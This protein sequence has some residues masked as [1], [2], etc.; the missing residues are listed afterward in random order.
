MERAFSK[1]AG[2]QTDGQ[3]HKRTPHRHVAL[4]VSGQWTR[5]IGTG[6]GRRAS[7]AAGCLFG[8]ILQQAEAGRLA[9]QCFEAKRGSQTD[10]RTDGRTDRR[11][12]ASSSRV[13]L[14]TGCA[15]V[16]MLAAFS[17]A[18]LVWNDP[19][20]LCS[21]GAL[22]PCAF[23]NSRARARALLSLLLPLLLPLLSSDK[24]RDALAKLYGDCA[25]S[26]HTH[27]SPPPPPPPL[28]NLLLLRLADWRCLADWRRVVIVVRRGAQTARPSRP[29]AADILYLGYARTCV[30][31]ASE[32]PERTHRGDR[33]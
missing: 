17:F 23:V 22:V 24:A 25:K 5:E 32:P 6:R 15:C 20:C 12:G 14:A 18:S 30:S 19:V 28:L 16:Q 33:R 21:R 4:S 26:A 1:Q 8:G 11:T 27:R 3:A 9:T 31:C 13:G 2:R 7:L 29:I 10:R